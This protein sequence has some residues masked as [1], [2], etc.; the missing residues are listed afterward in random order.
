MDK[1][2]H[3][4]QY[5]HHH[6]G[7]NPFNILLASMCHDISFAFELSTNL[8]SMSFKFFAIGDLQS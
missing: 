4:N 6:G 2:P 3:N 5:L 1:K 8:R 7:F